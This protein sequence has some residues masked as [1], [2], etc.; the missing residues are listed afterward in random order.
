M[1]TGPAVPDMARVH[2]VRSGDAPMPPPGVAR[3]VGVMSAYPAP[4]RTVTY[5]PHQQVPL[6][7]RGRG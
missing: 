4:G 5:P 1:S 3:V 6:P 7:L 2:P